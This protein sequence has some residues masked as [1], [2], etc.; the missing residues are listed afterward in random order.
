MKKKLLII[1]GSGF[2][3]QNLIKKLNFANYNIFSIS[4]RKSIKIRKRKSLNQIKLDISQKNQ[5]KKISNINFNIIINLG[6]NI[7]HKNYLET[8]KVHY[9]GVKNLISELNLESLNMFIQVGSSLEYG[10]QR[11][12]H[13]NN[14]NCKP[15]SNYGKAKFK[16]SK[17][18]KSQSKN[19]NFKFI[20]L[21]P[22]QIYGPYQKFDRLIPHV[23]RSCL[24][25]K[26]FDCTDGFQLRDFLYVE[27]FV[28]LIKK[29]LKNKNIKSGVFNVGFGK[30]YKVRYVIN[31]ICSIIKKGKPNFGN[32]KM[33]KDEVQSLYPSITKT[34]KNLNWRPIISLNKGLKKTI[35][36]YS[37][38]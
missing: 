20:I 36:Y 27:D 34:K 29:I 14:L 30:P 22:Y 26:S 21:R 33:R 8:N 19:K 37:K 18:I 15:I 1:G 28:S 25:N 38:K 16:A 24:R 12:P 13:F 6:G 10:K 17:F 2:L 9:I 11:A 4:L 35:N 32:I 23:I 3:G 31:L 7:D 5:I